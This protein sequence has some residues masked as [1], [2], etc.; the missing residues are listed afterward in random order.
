MGRLG[1]NPDLCAEL[2]RNIEDEAAAREKYYILLNRFLPE[3]SDSELRDI[4][5]IISE[6]MKHTNIL[7]Q[8]IFRRNGIIAED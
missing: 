2:E 8:M 4:E 3:L 7:T 5:E 1:Y 6:E